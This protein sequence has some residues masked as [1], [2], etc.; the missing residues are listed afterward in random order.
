MFTL[1]TTQ[2]LVK[3][4]G[5][6]SQDQPQPPTT[7]LGDWYANLLRL[8]HRQMILCTSERSLLS[9]VLA[10]RQVRVA[11]VPE[12]RSVVRQTLRAIGIPTAAIERELAEMES[13]SVA[14]TVSRSVLGSMNDFATAIEYR[15]LREPDTPLSAFAEWLAETACGPLGYDHPSLVAARLL[16]GKRAG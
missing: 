5:G 3:R 6:V 4:M 10:A 2:K 14:G 16:E 9:V 15:L 11:L 7:A 1:R 12:L 13:F 8:G